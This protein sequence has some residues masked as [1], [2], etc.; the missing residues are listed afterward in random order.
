M[1]FKSQASIEIAPTRKQGG[2]RWLAQQNILKWGGQRLSQTVRELI[3]LLD[4]APANWSRGYCY[5]YASF[6]K[7]VSATYCNPPEILILVSQ[8]QKVSTVLM[9]DP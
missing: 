4:Q 5:L 3:G 2:K 6:D 1:I 8:A 9:S 7:L